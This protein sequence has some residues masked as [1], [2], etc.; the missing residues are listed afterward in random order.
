M[1]RAERLAA[2]EGNI[3]DAGVGDARGDVQRL[4]ARQ[5]VAPRLVRAG[6]LAA[7][8][9]ARAAAIGQLPGE[10]KGRAVSSTGAPCIDKLG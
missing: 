5:L 7:R 2:A 4:V 9:A 10:E 1:R 3:G 6:F 8:E